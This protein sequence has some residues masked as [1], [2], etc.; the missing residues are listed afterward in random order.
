MLLGAAKYLAENRNSFYG[1]VYFIFQPAEEKEDGALTMI[2][3][4]L[5]ER[6]PMDAIYGLHNDPRI[7]VGHFAIRSGP[8]MAADDTW[9]V[10][11]RGTGGHGALPHLATDV[12]VLVAEFIL[13]LQ[14][15]VS[16]NIRPTD[17]AVISVGAIQS[18]SFGSL[19]VLPS[20][21]RVGGI[22]RSFTEEVR[23]TIERRMQELAHGL[24]T[25]FGCAAEVVYNRELPPLV[26]DVHSTER[27]IK[28][29]GSFV[30]AEN[31]DGNTTPI[32]AS[33]DFAEMLKEKPGAYISMGNGNKS[34]EV[35]SP[36]YNFNDDATIFGVGYWISLVQQELQN[37]LRVSAL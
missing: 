25:S 17:S 32:M 35:H 21:I 7:A 24:A 22:A 28:A 30:G 8:M 10:T 36:T 26:N 9:V 16:R 31:V 23:D 12:I 37:E 4:K 14:T 5:F 3:D 34:G 15:I 6:F 18:G 13:S 11:F 1:T 27:A 19:N 2:K 33:E 29:A 20:E